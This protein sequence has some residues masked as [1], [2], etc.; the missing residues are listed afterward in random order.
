MGIGEG[1]FLEIRKTLKR[2]YNVP[3]ADD[4][5]GDDWGV[6]EQ[7]EAFLSYLNFLKMNLGGQTAVRVDASWASQVSAI[8]GFS[9]FAMPD[10]VV[11][12]DAAET[13]LAMICELLDIQMAAL[14]EPEADEIPLSD[15]YDDEVEAAVREVY[16]RDYMSFGFG[17]W[18]GPA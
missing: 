7:K 18:E 12:E 16:Q 6:T 1:S 5:P 15:L 17:P 8:Q 14:P 10:M 4:G 3:L 9:E 2:V 13:E 11:R